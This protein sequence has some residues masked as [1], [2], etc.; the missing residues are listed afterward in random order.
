M[1]DLDRKV[2][3][4]NSVKTGDDFTRS[5]DNLPASNDVKG[6]NLQALDDTHKNEGGAAVEEVSPLGREFGAFSVICLNLSQMVRLL[7]YHLFHILKYT[8]R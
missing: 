5:G 4:S 1:P 2:S 8:T 6:I 7:I 3:P